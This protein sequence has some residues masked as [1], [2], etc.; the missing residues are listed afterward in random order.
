MNP[1]EK[2]RDLKLAAPIAVVGMG[3]S[4]RSVL[5]CLEK[6][7]YPVRGYDEHSADG[8]CQVSFDDPS[9]F[10]G[11][12]TLV[13]SPGV[14][15][16][17]AALARANAEVINDIEIFARLAEPP[18]AALTGSNGKSTVACM[19]AESV[20]ALGLSVRLCGNIGRPVLDAL[21]DWPEDRDLY[22]VELSSYQLELC[23]SL[24]VDVAAVLNVSPDHLDRY[25]SYGDYI[26]AKANLARQSRVCIF[27][28]DDPVCVEMARLARQAVFFGRG[29]DHRV[30]KGGLWVDNRMVIAADALAVHGNAN[31]DN[32]LAALLM[33]RSLGISEDDLAVPLCAF[34]GLAHRMTE[35]DQSGDVLFLD[36]SKATNTAAAIAALDGAERPTWLIAGGVG[37]GQDFSAFAQAIRAAP[38]REVLLI[39]VD[40]RTML[41]AFAAAGV[42]YRVCGDL[43]SAVAYAKAR[44]VA[45]DQVLLSP[46]TASFDQF[47]GFAERGERFAEAVRQK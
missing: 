19:L 47:G 2:L 46:A 40:N 3:T 23:P 38:V 36:D 17:R 14:D 18:I 41:A 37:K 4:G 43:A 8:A 6:A 44:A 35:V 26:A 27:N 24:R 39:G 25:N 45:G 12:A 33:G 9:V 11:A 32:A 15:R 42:P 16:R 21:F 28:G 1:L 20:R 10:A 31:L 13:V 22:V 30:E 29:R 7:G 5:R 34:R